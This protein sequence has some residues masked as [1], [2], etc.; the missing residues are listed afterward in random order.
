LAPGVEGLTGELAAGAVLATDD[1][2]R[3]A[4]GGE[5]E[6][7]TK[8]DERRG[9]ADPYVEGVNRGRLHRERNR[10]ADP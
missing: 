10:Q 1:A 7:S 3:V 2:A 4:N 8:R 5:A 9:D 6:Q